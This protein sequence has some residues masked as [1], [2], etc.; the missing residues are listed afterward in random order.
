M[1]YLKIM[2]KLF[3]RFFLVFLLLIAISYLPLTNVFATTCNSSDCTN[4]DDCQRKIQECQEIIAAYQP[5]QS[6]NKEQ[7]AALEKQLNNTEKLIKAAEAQLGKVEKETF[8]RQAALDYQKEV[9]NTRV[10]D[11]YIRSRGFSL[12]LFFISIS[13]GHP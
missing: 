10:R 8:D 6:K 11:F 9:F 2:S 1:I 13:P 3:F 4:P 7:L 12:F 5:A